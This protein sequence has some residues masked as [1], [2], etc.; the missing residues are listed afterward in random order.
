MGIDADWIS[1]KRAVEIYGGGNAYSWYRSEAARSGSVHMGGLTV[2]AVKI[3]GRWMVAAQDV[4]NAIQAQRADEAALAQRTADYEGGVLHEGPSV[5]VAWG[6]YSV[7][8]SFHLATIPQ[9]M[10]P[11][12]SWWK[13]NICRGSAATEHNGQE[14]HRCR[15][16]SPCGNDCTLTGISC[17]TCGTS[18]TF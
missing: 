18:L 14:C 12:E 3:S 10:A 8:G 15:D 9:R 2:S 7:R 5:R 1:L 11:S 6:T 16:W 4:A 17:P 13:C